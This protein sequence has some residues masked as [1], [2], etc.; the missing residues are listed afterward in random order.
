[1]NW[2]QWKN[3]LTTEQISILK[4]M[5]DS[6]HYKR[7]QEMVTEFCLILN[8]ILIFEEKMYEPTNMLEKHWHVEQ[9]QTVPFGAPNRKGNYVTNKKRFF[10][11]IH[12]NWNLGNIEIVKCLIENGAN[13]N[14]KDKSGSTAL[15]YASEYGK[16]LH[17]FYWIKWWSTNFF[18][19]RW[20]LAPLRKCVK[21]KCFA[22]LRT[23]GSHEISHWKWDRCQY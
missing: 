20:K 3:L 5:M 9:L 15:H 11:E 19:K 18:K 6:I 12:L 14:A 21:L 16:I 13:I 7:L 23:L 17:E 1:M 8:W 10:F 2:T 22:F 4:T